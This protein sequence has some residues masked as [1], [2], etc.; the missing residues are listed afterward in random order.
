MFIM[1]ISNQF[2]IFT[3][4]NLFFS[5]IVEF[6]ILMFAVMINDHL[7]RVWISFTLAALTIPN[8]TDAHCAHKQNVAVE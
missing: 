6:S 5:F 8:T 4:K 1:A 3:Y 7:L 2:A